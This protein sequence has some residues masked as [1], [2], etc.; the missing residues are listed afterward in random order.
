MRVSWPS[1]S[2]D[3]SKHQALEKEVSAAAHTD[4]FE[5]EIA[6]LISNLDVETETVLVEYRDI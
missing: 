4:A 2:R 3:S 1:C 5:K 6:K